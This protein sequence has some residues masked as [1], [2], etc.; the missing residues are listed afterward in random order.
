M[1]YARSSRIAPVTED[2]RGLDIACQIMRGYDKAFRKSVKFVDGAVFQPGEWCFIDADG[3]AQRAVAE[4]KNTACLCISGNER[5][6]AIGNKEVTI[7][8]NSNLV[9]KSDKYNKQGTYV[10]G[11]ELTVKNV[12][13]GFSAVTPAAAGDYIVGKVTEAGAGYLVYEVYATI[14]KKA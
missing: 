13:N 1:E 2:L 4:S 3:R 8:Q 6:D 14:V 7:V 12:G 11:T 10:V 5:F 9:V